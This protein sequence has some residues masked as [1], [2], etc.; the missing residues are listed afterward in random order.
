MK[1]TL[2]LALI[3]L[4]LFSHAQ[5]YFGEIDVFFV[6]MN[7]FINNVLVP[8]IFT[9]SLLF[10][11]YG[12]YK[13]FIYEGAVS[14]VEREKGKD[15]MIYAVIGF[16][17]MVSIWGIVNLVASGLFTGIGGNAPVPTLPGIPTL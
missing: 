10:F 4:P 14:E 16:V 17:L 7:G 5:E 1:Y 9:L 12:M 13:F 11:I 6:R 15:L 8:F 2:A 3:A